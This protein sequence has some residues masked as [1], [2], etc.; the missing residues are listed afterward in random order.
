MNVT[1][2]YI[3]RDIRPLDIGS[4]LLVRGCNCAGVCLYVIHSSLD[5]ILDSLQKA[6]YA[7]GKSSELIVTKRLAKAVICNS[8]HTTSPL[9]KEITLTIHVRVKKSRDFLEQRFELVSPG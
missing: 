6:T 4:L 2:V 7:E 3:S 8:P 9:L 1:A 5:D